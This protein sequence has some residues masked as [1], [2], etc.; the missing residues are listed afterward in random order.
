MCWI[1]DFGAEEKELN[2]RLLDL[3]SEWKSCYAQLVEDDE[4][5]NWVQEFFSWVRDRME[6]LHRD[7][8]PHEP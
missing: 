6:E 8:R 5:V 4:H 7:G 2:A 1:P 3:F